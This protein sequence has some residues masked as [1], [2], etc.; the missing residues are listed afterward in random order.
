MQ[1]ERESF[2]SRFSF[3]V[4]SVSCAIGLGNIW[5]MPYRAGTYGGALYILLVTA[6]IFLLA[7]PVLLTEYSVGRGSRQ[8]TANCFNVLQPKGT[9]WFLNGYVGIAGNYLLLMFYIMVCGFALGYFWKG[10]SGALIG[11]PPEYVV[12]S[13]QALTGNPVESVRLMIAIIVMGMGICYLGLRKGV[14][15]VCKYVMGAFFVLLLIL[16]VRSV[17]L[18]GATEGL[19]FLFIPNL[20]AMRQHGTFRIIHMAM[21]QALFS[22]SVGIGSM[23]I[24]G[25]YINKEK[26]LFRDAFT[27][28][29]LDLSVII[30]CLLMIFPA[31]FAFGISP[32]V[33]EGLLFVTLPNIF[34]AMPGSYFWS[35]IFYAGLTFVAFSTALAVMEN[36]TAIGMDKFGWSRAKSA[37]INMGLLILLCLPSALT[38][39]IMAGV[40]VPPGFPHIGAFFT[41]LVMEIIL[42]I[43]SLL[44]VLFC[45][46]KK[47]WGWNNF[48]AEANSG[49]EGWLFPTSL[50]FYM[51]YIVPIVIIF[52]FIFGQLQ[53]WVLSPLG[54]LI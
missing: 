22:L 28:G 38:R 30:L 46:S 23:A 27:V 42:P 54:I 36:I 1:K 49:N 25:S 53:R 2:T 41:Y 16:L 50:R 26:R 32:A 20:D 13:W 48:I 29:V 7:I 47:G 52:I 45:M 35:L 24:F 12:A 17:T 4:M 43:G 9:K 5:L 3:I 10:L 39:N 8:S 40:L 14:E 18:P 37:G 21:G 15:R 31:A 6:F 34:N 51:T 44:Y 19:R 11:Q 33:G